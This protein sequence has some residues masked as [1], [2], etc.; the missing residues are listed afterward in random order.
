MLVDNSA[1]GPIYSTWGLQQL[2]ER[3]RDQS[4]TFHTALCAVPAAAEYILSP[5]GG[6]KN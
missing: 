6:H 5:T 4:P 3:E 2:Y 1:N